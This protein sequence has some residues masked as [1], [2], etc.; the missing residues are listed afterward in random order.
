M[1]N[2]IL[3]Q[4]WTQAIVATGV[5]LSL[6]Q[7]SA[8]WLMALMV[9]LGSSVAL[10]GPSTSHAQSAATPVVA[11][12]NINTADAT[13][14]AAGLKG[15]GQS[16]ALEIVRYREAYGPFSTV[17]ELAEVKGIGQSTLEQN[18]ALITLE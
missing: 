7:F 2:L 3:L 14:L 10:L 6:R 13:A 9:A 5:F 17:D 8:A 15:I 16:R 11:T 12:I 18:R 1:N 4:N